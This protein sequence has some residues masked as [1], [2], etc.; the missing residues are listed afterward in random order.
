M[1]SKRA[2]RHRVIKEMWPDLGTVMAELIIRKAKDEAAD[3][4]GGIVGS[5]QNI[6]STS[7]NRTSA[8]LGYIS[9]D[10]N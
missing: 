1:A 8:F 4:D 3:E 5:L 9:Y 10:Y 6:P 2:T 7:R